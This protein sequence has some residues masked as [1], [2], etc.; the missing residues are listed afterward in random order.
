MGEA[1]R[2]KLAG[3]YPNPNDPR[4][5]A[6]YAKSFDPEIEATVR[7]ITDSPAFAQ[8]CATLRSLVTP[9]QDDPPSPTDEK[10]DA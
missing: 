4:S 3:T 6:S 10:P 5:V 2:R 7:A 9:P 1:K 8:L